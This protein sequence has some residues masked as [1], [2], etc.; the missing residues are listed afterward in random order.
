MIAPGPWLSRSRPGPATRPVALT[1]EQR[2][3]VEA[4]IRPGKAEHRVVRRGQALLLMAD[5]VSVSDTAMLLGAHIR[6]VYEWRQRF[7]GA[8]DPAAK[9]VDAPRSGRPPSLSLSLTP[10]R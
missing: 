9:L 6:T 8:A 4:E 5:G 1:A 7:I 2:A 3:A 10:P